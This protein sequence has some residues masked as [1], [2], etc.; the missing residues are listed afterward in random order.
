MTTIKIIDCTI[1]KNKGKHDEIYLQTHLPSNIN[2][3]YD[4]NLKFIT[5]ENNGENYC[6]KYFPNLPITIRNVN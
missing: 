5:Q 4:L 2:T 6:K 1:I 3:M